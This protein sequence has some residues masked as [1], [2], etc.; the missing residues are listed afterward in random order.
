MLQQSWCR[1]EG[2]GNGQGCSGLQ[3]GLEGEASE[4]CPQQREEVKAEEQTAA[5][6]VLFTAELLPAPKESSLIQPFLRIPSYLHP[7][8]DLLVDSRSNQIGSQY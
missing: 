6:P 8:V 5:F 2:L 3:S 1:A 4:R 7:G